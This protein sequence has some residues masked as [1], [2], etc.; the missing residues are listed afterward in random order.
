MSSIMLAG[1][2]CWWQ[3]LALY[4]HPWGLE[5]GDGD[6]IPIPDKIPFTYPLTLCGS[7]TERAEAIVVDN[8]PCLHSWHKL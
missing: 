2:Y 8:R 5:L 6:S 7:D 4:R 1:P 3:L